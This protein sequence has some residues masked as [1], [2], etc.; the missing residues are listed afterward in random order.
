MPLPRKTILIADDE[1]HVTF[2]LAMK[3]TRPNTTVLVANDGAEGLN[4]ARTHRPD[5]IITDFQMPRMSGFEMACQLRQGEATA[6]TPVI[7]LTARGH[8]LSPA[9]LCRTNIQHLI[10]KPFSARDLLAKVAEYIDLEEPA[11]QANSGGEA[12]GLA[13]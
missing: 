10:P 11:A 13:A 7:M 5:L 6:E 4:L 3:L 1:P 8:R 2:M 12:R 9:D